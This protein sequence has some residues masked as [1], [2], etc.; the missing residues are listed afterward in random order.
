MIATGTKVRE[1]TGAITWRARQA[2]PVVFTNGVFDLVHP[3]HVELLEADD[4]P[5]GKNELTCRRETHDPRADDEHVDPF[6][7][8][9]LGGD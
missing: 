5:A 1:L 6:H 7:D 2:G 4:T 8:P 3:G 9:M